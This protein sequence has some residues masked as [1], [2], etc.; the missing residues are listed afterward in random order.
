MFAHVGV[1]RT[2]CFLADR[3]RAFEK[4]LRVSVL[5]LISIRV[6]QVVQALAYIT[7]IRAQH[8]FADRQSPLKQPLASTCLPCDW[9]AMPSL[10]R[11]RA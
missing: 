2:E 8:F 6:G 1:V 11:A 5:A 10:L 7:I 3:Q 9:N 4:R